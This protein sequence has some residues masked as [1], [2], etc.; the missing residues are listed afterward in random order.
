MGPTGEDNATATSQ[1]HTAAASLTWAERAQEFLRPGHGRRGFAAWPATFFDIARITWRGL[2]LVSWQLI[3]YGAW[4]SSLPFVSGARARAYRRRVLRA[5][6]RGMLSIL[7]V[8]V[9]TEGV[10]PSPPFF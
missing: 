6:G 3:T 2:L 5:W 8:R 7:G 4:A 1:F 9:E 10:P